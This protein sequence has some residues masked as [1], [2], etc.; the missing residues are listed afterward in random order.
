MI[1]V[2]IL[3]KENQLKNIKILKMIANKTLMKPFEIIL[4][5]FYVKM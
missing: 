2:M 3:W 4:P 1:G 5:Y